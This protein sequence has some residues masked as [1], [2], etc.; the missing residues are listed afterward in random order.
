MVD[1]RKL[2]I[3]PIMAFSTF[4]V[5]MYI[6]MIGFELPPEASVGGNE[7]LR[8]IVNS[9]NLSGVAVLDT[10]VE[11]LSTLGDFKI[12]FIDGW[13]FQGKWDNA[14][15]ISGVRG[16]IVN[17]VPT[18]VFGGD[19]DLLYDLADETM[20]ET[21]N[22]PTIAHGVYFDG[23]INDWLFIGGT[24]LTQPAVIDAYNWSVNKL[25][26]TYQPA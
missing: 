16:I 3:I 11:D 5:L 1:L 6:G 13:W 15:I 25:S 12:L 20:R 17:S 10:E 22:Q 2:I 21:T 19:G 24:E 23:D 4:F 14:T 7:N 8:D 18:V 9:L 26:N